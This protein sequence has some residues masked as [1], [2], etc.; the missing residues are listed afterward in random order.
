MP[1]NVTPET[2]HT[3]PCGSPPGVLTSS[4][5]GR[6]SGHRRR[7][8]A[9][10]GGVRGRRDPC[11]LSTKGVR[12]DAD[13]DGY[14]GGRTSR[15][16]HPLRTL[17]EYRPGDPAPRA[18][19]VIGTASL[20]ARAGPC[21]TSLRGRS[22]PPSR[23]RVRMIVAGTPSRVADSALLKPPWYL[24]RT[25]CRCRSGRRESADRTSP[26]SASTSCPTHELADQRSGS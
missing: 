18:G 8:S 13:T 11:R 12:R 9:G 2:S 23:S 4:A 21:G 6:R 16:T 19:L 14:E 15:H 20:V 26:W 10:Y 5:T 24:S 7:T 3:Y 17:T 25:A 1:L 22:M